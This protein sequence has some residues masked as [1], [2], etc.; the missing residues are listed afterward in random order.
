MFDMAGG[1][2]YCPYLL[3][4]CSLPLIAC[5]SAVHL[6]SDPLFHK[7]IKEK[8]NHGILLMNNLQIPFFFFFLS[9]TDTYS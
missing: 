6:L 7:K 8:K 3:P 2:A 5:V 9:E 1:S 4:T